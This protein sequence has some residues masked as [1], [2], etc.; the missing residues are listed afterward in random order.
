MLI[1]YP[2]LRQALAPDTL[3]NLVREFLIRQIGDEGFDQVDPAQLAEGMAKVHKA[4]QVGDLVVE[5]SEEDE[6]VA[7]RP[8]E[9]VAPG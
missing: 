6:S 1:D 8:R 3:D 9:E 5:Y 2:T 4:L 7:I